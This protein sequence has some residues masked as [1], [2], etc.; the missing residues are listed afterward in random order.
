M[1]VHLLQGSDGRGGL[2]LLPQVH[3]RVEQRQQDQQH[4]RAEL[5]ERVDAADAG[6]EQAALHRSLCWRANAC[7]RG[8]ALPAASL[9]GRTA[10]PARSPRPS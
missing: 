5:L 6:G 1:T 7:Q 2:A 9:L 3:D 8:P 10:R 4:A